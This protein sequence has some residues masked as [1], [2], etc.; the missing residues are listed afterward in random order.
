M[1]EQSKWQTRGFAYWTRLS[2]LQRTL[3]DNGGTVGTLTAA[4][5]ASPGDPSAEDATQAIK[6]W[7][8]AGKGHDEGCAGYNGGAL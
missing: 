5:L 7:F 2:I 1:L 8:E 3:R 4:V 6:R